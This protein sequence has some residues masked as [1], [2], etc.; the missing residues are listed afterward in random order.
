VGIVVAVFGMRLI[1]PVAI[2]AVTADM[3]FVEVVQLAL[4]DPKLYSA[5][6]M[7][8][9]PEIAAFGGAF[10]M[11]VFLNFFLDEG[12]D[13]HWFKFLERRLANLASVPA[14]SVFVTLIALLVMASYV[15]EA[16]R[17]VVTMAGIWGI[18]IY[19]GVQVLGHLLGGEPEV[20]ENGNAIAH[21]SNG[22]PTGVVKAG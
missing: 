20:D 18:V 9:H 7:A 10:L 8:H 17:L 19:I 16:K 12:K 14:M 2:V 1:F 21:D 3:G 6:L 15:D 11:L 13:T 22:A 4:N 5:K